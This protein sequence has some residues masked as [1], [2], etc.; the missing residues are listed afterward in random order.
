MWSA[1]HEALAA[2]EADEAQTIVFN[3]CGHGHFDLSAYDDFRAGK[4]QDYEYPEE[5]IEASLAGLPQVD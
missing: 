4:L 1:Q 3:L 5:E 2:K